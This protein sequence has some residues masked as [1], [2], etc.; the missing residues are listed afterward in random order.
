MNWYEFIAPFFD[1]MGITPPD[2]I[3]AVGIM[4]GLL[5]GA[6]DYRIGL[7]ATLMILISMTSFFI[8]YGFDTMRMFILIFCCIVI[9]ALSIFAEGNKNSGGFI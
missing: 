6:A 7:M 2:A 1:W 9:M 4:C 8:F 3:A 5:F